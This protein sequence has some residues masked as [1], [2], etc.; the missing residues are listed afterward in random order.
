MRNEF[1]RVRRKWLDRDRVHRHGEHRFARIRDR[2]GA[3]AGE[4]SQDS[5]W[6]R[7]VCCSDSLLEYNYLMFQTPVKE[8]QATGKFLLDFGARKVQVKLKDGRVSLVREPESGGHAH[9]FDGGVRDVRSGTRRVLH[10]K[11]DR[12]VKAYAYH[13][14]SGAKLELERMNGVFRVPSRACSPYSQSN[15]K[16][17]ISRTNSSLRRWNR[18]R[19]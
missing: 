7:L 11:G 16:N 13:E 17:S 14:G 8:L 15:S 4:G 10:P 1:I 12:G 9:S 2:S 18:S 6:H 3:A 19:T 5:Y